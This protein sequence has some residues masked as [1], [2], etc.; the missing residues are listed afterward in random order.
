[1]AKSKADEWLGQDKLTLLEGWAR[2]GLTD[3]QIAHNMGIA[4]STFYDWKNKYSEISKS[5]KK[6]KEIVDIEVENALLKKA[7]GYNV[8]V[9]K[10]FKVK[11]VIYQ[12]GKRLKET[13][14][15][16]YAEEEIHIPADTTAQIFW[17]KNRKPDKWRDKV[18]DTENEEAITNATDILVK[19]RKTVD[20]RYERS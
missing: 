2:D 12:D 19:I 10:A 20:D 18:V 17:L 11:E 16:E 15:I 9:Q 8:P 6:N 5:L 1:M 14:R 7:L 13:E 4:T 3:E